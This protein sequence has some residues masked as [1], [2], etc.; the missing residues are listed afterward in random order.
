MA[1]LNPGIPDVP[2]HRLTGDDLFSPNRRTMIRGLEVRARA[3]APSSALAKVY[4]A[5]RPYADKDTLLPEGISETLFRFLCVSAGIRLWESLEVTPL[6]PTEILIAHFFNGEPLRKLA[7]RPG[8]PSRSQLSRLIQETVATLWERMP[9]QASAFPIDKY[10][11]FPLSALRRSHQGTAQKLGST[12]QRRDWKTN[13][14]RYSSE[15]VRNRQK[16][17]QD[18][19]RLE[20]DSVNPANGEFVAARP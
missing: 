17:Q 1:G 3:M 9:R 6:T 11:D 20:H 16:A 15:A 19:R 8:Y 5:A 18:R 13:Q 12:A 7:E 4:S 10:S 2:A 14:K